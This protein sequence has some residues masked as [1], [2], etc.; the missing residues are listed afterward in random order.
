MAEQWATSGFQDTFLFEPFASRTDGHDWEPTV[1]KRVLDRVCQD[2][3]PYLVLVTSADFIWEL[4]AG[5]NVGERQGHQHAIEEILV[6]LAGIRTGMVATTFWVWTQAP[7]DRGTISC[8]EG[9][10]WKQ[11][12]GKRMAI[13]AVLVARTKRRKG[14]PGGSRT[15]S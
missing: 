7:W 14:G 8:S 5:R 10:S 2:H 6:R 1:V 4:A 3:R 9:S 12:P 15:T 13:N 11:V